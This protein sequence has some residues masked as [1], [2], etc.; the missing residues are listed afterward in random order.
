MWR[1]REEEEE[2]EEIEE[3][4]E[5]EEKE[6]RA[7]IGD[8]MEDGLRE[9]VKEDLMSTKEK[10]GEIEKR[11]KGE[12][13][14]RI[15]M[16]GMIGKRK[17]GEHITTKEKKRAEEIKKRKRGVGK[18]KN[19]GEEKLP[20]VETVKVRGMREVNVELARMKELTGEN[21]GEAVDMVKMRE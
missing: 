1:R 10:I 6:D 21:A 16:K 2:K 5:E 4:K 13:E 9:M 8:R 7:M 20:A 15:I 19:Q 3:K 17:N 14:V 18:T 12:R 11:T